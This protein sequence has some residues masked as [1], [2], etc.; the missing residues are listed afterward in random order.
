V[1]R[2]LWNRIRTWWLHRRARNRPP[3]AEIVALPGAARV[4]FRRPKG[5]TLHWSPDQWGL[6]F[7][8]QPLPARWTREFEA[9]DCERCRILGLP[10][11]TKYRLNTR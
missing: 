2:R 9:A 4:E 6:P 11:V 10:M 3:A 8:G 7:C 1:I 5:E